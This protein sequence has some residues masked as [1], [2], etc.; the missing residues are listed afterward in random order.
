[1]SEK[2][3]IQKTDFLSNL[4]NQKPNTSSKVVIKFLKS[5][6]IKFL[7]RRKLRRSIMGRSI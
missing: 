5:T 6:K 1:M 7:A 2:E 4:R 3:N